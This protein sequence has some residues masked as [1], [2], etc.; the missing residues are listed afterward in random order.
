MLML[1]VA[2]R[3][4]NGNASGVKGGM[5]GRRTGGVEQSARSSLGGERY[6]K[7]DGVERIEHQREKR[8]RWKDAPKEQKGASFWFAKNEG[9]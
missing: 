9:N 2:L 6:W 5:W 1:S 4:G 8:N 7:G 3:L